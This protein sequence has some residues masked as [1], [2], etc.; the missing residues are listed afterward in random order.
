MLFATPL[1]KEQMEALG[2]IVQDVRYIGVA[3]ETALAPNYPNPFNP[4]TVIAY[5]IAQRGHVE[6]CVHDARGTVIR[7]LV[8]RSLDAGKYS[9]HFNASG[10]PA[11]VYLLQLR[12]VNRVLTRKMLLL[13]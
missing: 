2:G 9:V 3:E 12:T 13:K 6:L 1:R 10:L 7:R 11:G 5:S 4:S 8:S